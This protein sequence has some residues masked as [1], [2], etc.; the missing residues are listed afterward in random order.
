LT[1][2]TK[3]ATGKYELIVLLPSQFSSDGFPVMIK[4]P[5]TQC[6]TAFYTS[7]DGF[8]HEGSPTGPRLPAFSSRGDVGRDVTLNPILVNLA[9]AIRLRWLD[10]QIPGWRNT[11]HVEAL[12]VLTEVE[13]LYTAVVFVPWKL[14]PTSIKSSLQSSG[15]GVQPTM[16]REDAEKLM[17]IGDFSL[18]LLGPATF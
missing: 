1:S 15:T 13:E 6:P 11:L 8:L 5:I 4:H 17:H 10:Q 7:S 16:R 18:C 14:P 12:E 2:V 9:A 3:Y